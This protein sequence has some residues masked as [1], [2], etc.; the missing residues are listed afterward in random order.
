MYNAFGYDQN[1]VSL[2]MIAALIIAML[3]TFI[4]T[5]CCIKYS[6]QL[7]KLERL[8]GLN[9]V[10]FV[11]LVFMLYFNINI[12]ITFVLIIMSTTLMLLKK[13]I[14][15]EEAIKY[16]RVLAPGCTLYTTSLLGTG[17]LIPILLINSFLGKLLDSAKRE[18]YLLAGL[19]IAFI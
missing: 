11:S 9:V 19:I 12:Y 13:L 16:C 4:Y 15:Y 3:T 1:R 5:K 10:G 2:G 8:A 6:D 7:L 18:T 14:L 17:D